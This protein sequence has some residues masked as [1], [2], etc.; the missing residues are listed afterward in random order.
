[1]CVASLLLSQRLDWLTG[2]L[3]RPRSERDKADDSAAKDSIR[4]FTANLLS[5]L[6][7]LPSDRN[8]ADR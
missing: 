6:P 4:A 5:V 2:A 1:M 8:R 7:I 3:E